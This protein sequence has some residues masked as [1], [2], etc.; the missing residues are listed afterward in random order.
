MYFG[1]MYTLVI[2]ICLLCVN[3]LFMVQLFRKCAEE[4]NDHDLHVLK[5]HLRN[6]RIDEFFDLIKEKSYSADDLRSDHNTILRNAAKYGHAQV[7]DYL[8][9]T[10]NFSND[11]VNSACYQEFIPTKE[12]IMHVQK[13]P[14]LWWA[15][16]NGNVSVARSMRKKYGI[17]TRVIIEGAFPRIKREDFLP[18][19]GMFAC[20]RDDF[21][22]P[23][24]EFQ[25]LCEGDSS[26]LAQ[27]A[28]NNKLDLFVWL[29]D[30]V[31]IDTSKIERIGKLAQK[32]IKH[33]YLELLREF[34]TRLAI[35]GAEIRERHNYSVTCAL[36]N[37][38][39]GVLEYLRE[40]Y[41]INVND[42]IMA[43]KYYIS[44]K[45]YVDM[46]KKW[47]D[48]HTYI[49]TLEDNEN[50]RAYLQGEFNLTP[51]ELRTC[52]ELYEIEDEDEE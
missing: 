42:I 48:V 9:D 21:E 31:N 29:C 10:H 24:E 4:M 40:V 7:L 51:T 33:G 11:D 14:V 41:Y 19:V 50:V 20:F 2:R 39:F 45:T 15:I 32:T 25:K 16:R 18:D 12:G 38:H 3:V 6:S 43:F 17:P 46:Y 35:G 1:D 13:K 47:P 34:S 49:L 36:V 44:N 37:Q 27:I 22:V 8:H 28:K 5:Q 23:D 26:F 30:V 52:L